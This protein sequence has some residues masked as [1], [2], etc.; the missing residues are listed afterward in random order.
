MNDF[1]VGLVYMISGTISMPNRI[2]EGLVF[3]SEQFP[4]TRVA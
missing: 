1:V 4:V 3:Q 2:T